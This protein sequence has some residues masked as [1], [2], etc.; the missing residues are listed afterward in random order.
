M[1]ILYVE[2]HL[3]IGVAKGQDAQADQLLRGVG[4]GTLFI[5]SV[6]YMEALSKLAYEARNSEAFLQ[7]VDDPIDDARRDASSAHA[8]LLVT[9]LMG[10][11]VAGQNRLNDIASRLNETLDQLSRV[12]E[13]VVASGEAIRRSIH[14]P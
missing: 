3:A 4:A 6:C 13:S 12:A 8:P 1:K 14:E 7:G 11:K 2:T 10:A 5:P 9:H